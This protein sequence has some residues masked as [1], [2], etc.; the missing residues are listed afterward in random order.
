MRNLGLRWIA[1]YHGPNPVAPAAVVVA[2]L[3]ADTMPSVSELLQAAKAA[4]RHS[5]LAMPASDEPSPGTG[6]DGLLVLGE[7]AASWARAALNEIRGYVLHAGAARSGDRVRVW[8]GF[9]R[10]ELSRDAL[11]LGLRHISAHLRNTKNIPQLKADIEKLLISCKKYHP[12]Y[13]ARILMVSADKQN[14]PFLPFIYNT[15]YWQFGWGV[16]SR[17]FLE[18]S[19]N[20]DGFLG[21]QWQRSKPLAKNLMA[22]LCLPIAPHV[23]VSAENELEAAAA[24]IGYPCVIKP[25]DSGGGKG[26]TAGIGDVESLRS[27]FHQAR[28][29][30][31]QALML[32]KHVSGADHRLMVADGRFVAAIRREPS[33]VTGDGRSTVAELIAHLNMARSSNMVRSMYLRPIIIDN[34]LKNHLTNQNLTLTDIPDAERSVTLRSNANLSTGGICV[35]ITSNC[36]P[37]LQKMV[38]ELA[39]TC[40]IST[41]GF[42]YIT[43]DITRP[44]SET[45]GVFIEMNTTPGLDACVAAGWPE[46]VIGECVLGHAIGRIPIDIT[47]V[48]AA[49]LDR[50]RHAL[51][52]QPLAEGDACACGNM[53]RVGAS[54]RHVPTTEPWAA[55]RSALRNKAVRHLHIFCSAED[56]QH[57]GLPVDYFKRSHVEIHGND[58]VLPAD[59]IKILKSHSKYKLCLQSLVDLIVVNS[60]KDDLSESTT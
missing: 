5:G 48:S 21:W 9:H 50:A 10:P 16:Y 31:Q 33:F 34:V 53:L 22:A 43:T 51:V 41:A 60:L 42:D 29:Y 2:E 18:S 55:A 17:V 23:L 25:I 3:S 24:R 46:E 11:I 36:H 6:E 30:S 27:A 1:E 19:S 45:G 37:E 47:V 57:L 56:L 7:A 15:R 58:S 59:W 4:W 52:S 44:A 32:E 38:E 8:I 40:G 49:G 20:E 26:V 13:Q 28:R 39:A 14:I 35:D 54:L 12:D